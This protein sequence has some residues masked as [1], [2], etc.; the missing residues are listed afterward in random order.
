M[1]RPL[2]LFTFFFVL[3]LCGCYTANKVEY[4]ADFWP[5]FKSTR[6]GECVNL[7][8]K[9]NVESCDV[10]EYSAISHRG[11]LNFPP[12]FNSS[13][14]SIVTIE[15][16]GCEKITIKYVDRF[17]HTRKNFISKERNQLAWDGKRNLFKYNVVDKEPDGFTPKKL[18]GYH[19]G[20]LGL[21]KDN[22]LLSE[23]KW[24]GWYFFFYPGRSYNNQR[25]R[26]ARSKGDGSPSNPGIKV[27]KVTFTTGID[28]AD[29][30]IDDLERVS[31]S[32]KNIFAH[33]SLE[34]PVL[35]TYQFIGKFYDAAGK[36]VLDHEMG[37]RPK[38]SLWNIWF[39]HEFDKTVDTPGKWK[40]S[41]FVDGKELTQVS[42][43]VDAQ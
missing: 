11:E 3:S 26:F 12:G 36:P 8:G 18:S 42:F 38:E 20:F 43:D 35:D 14:N 17:G 24:D 23:E 28:K 13:S 16:T 41:L 31:F 30:P 32:R 29:K 25:C 22:S 34:I 21:G 40:F 5:D 7:S 6:T 10:N 4:P 15:Q 19:Y 9:Y 2:C 39:F 1:K 27:I 33:I 37:M